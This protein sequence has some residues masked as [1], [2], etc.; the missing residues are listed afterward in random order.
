MKPTDPLVLSEGVMLFPVLE[1]DPAMRASLGAEE[2]DYGLTKPSSRRTTRIIDSAAANLLEEF[3]TP[4]S[5]PDAIARFGRKS[6]LA[7]GKV[8]EL[9]F[10]FLSKMVRDEF[11]IQVEDR[12]RQMGPVETAGGWR[13]LEPL[14]LLDDT[15]VYLVS[16]PLKERGVLKRVRPDAE[17]WIRLA[18]ANEARILRLLDGTIAPLLLEDGTGADTPYIVV[19]WRRG[20]PAQSAASQLRRPWLPNAKARLAKICTRILDAYV[21]LHDSGV[22]QGDVQPSNVLVDLDTDTVSII[23]FGL[24]ADANTPALPTALRGGVQAFYSPETARALLAGESLPPPTGASEQYAIAAMLYKLF[25]GHSYVEQR[26][27]PTAWYEAVC[28]SPPRP[29]ARVGVP[30]WP[31]LE[32]ALARG[33]AKD[34]GQ[35]FASMADFRDRFAAAVAT[36]SDS[37]APKTSRAW[38]PPGVFDIVVTRLTDPDD[39]RSRPLSRPSANLNYGASGI[40][41]FLYRASGILERPDLFAAA[42]LWIERA[43]REALLPADAFFDEARG[44]NEDTVGRSAVYHSAVGMHCVDALIASSANQPQRLR[45]AIGRF[46]AAAEMPERR[47]DLAT[48]YAGHLIGCAALLESLAALHHDE[49]RERVIALGQRRCSELLGA[50]GPVDRALPGTGESFFGIAHG[51]AGASYAMLRFAN[52]VGEAVSDK[53][54][55]TLRELAQAATVLGGAASWPMGSREDVWTG[56]CHGSAGYALLWSQA[57]RSIGNDEFLELATLAGEHVWASTLPETGQLCCGAAGQV[58]AFLAL[59]RLT[60]KSLYMD[61]ARQRLEHA[62]GFIGAHGMSPDSL[63]KGDL[64]IALL[65]CEIGDPFLAAMPMFESERWP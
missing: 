40:A 31:S 57:H 4:S 61:R 32:A 8:L 41:Y 25:T 62:T 55:E 12:A 5:I 24:A 13:V 64:G 49:E 37:L 9:S 2:G 46:I 33:L 53:V 51:W 15:E 56:W 17:R 27:E 58:Y 43:R 34:P 20:L 59:H 28:A 23:D 26:L 6:G 36:E 11:L 1:L 48:G 18:L 63:Y 50:W 65:E 16:S 60:G 45:E 35:R 38:R 10:E 29:F 19:E 39:V 3:R 44:L 30:P 14:R 42:D 7:P 21:K 22:M 47:A 52:A 54:T